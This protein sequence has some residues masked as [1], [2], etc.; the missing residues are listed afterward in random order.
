MIYLMPFSSELSTY[1]YS[2]FKFTNVNTVHPVCLF[3]LP[4]HCLTTKRC[5]RIIRLTFKLDTSHFRIR[6]LHL[7]VQLKIGALSDTSR[8]IFL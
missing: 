1:Y 2:K 8:K 6:E 4:L 5:F 7:K 3:F